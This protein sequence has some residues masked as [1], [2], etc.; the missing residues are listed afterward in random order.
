MVV[1]ER[2]HEKQVHPR[3]PLTLERGLTRGLHAT[4]IPCSRSQGSPFDDCLP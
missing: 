2:R 3:F 1:R 4:D